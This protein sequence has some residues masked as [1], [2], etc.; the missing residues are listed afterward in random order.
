MIVNQP[1]NQFK[2]T[3]NRQDDKLLTRFSDIIGCL[4]SWHVRLAELFVI[5]RVAMA[6]AWDA[7]Q[8]GDRYQHYE[9]YFSFRYTKHEICI[10][11]N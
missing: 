4:Y 11:R 7:I 8:C 1:F 10:L 3:D 9:S 6:E 2:R 5:S